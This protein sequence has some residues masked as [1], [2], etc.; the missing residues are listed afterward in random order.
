M[1]LL[2]ETRASGTKVCWFTL[3][4]LFS[5]AGYWCK[6]L[7]APDDTLLKL[8]PLCDWLC[9]IVSVKLDLVISLKAIHGRNEVICG[10]SMSRR[11]INI[12]QAT[13]TSSNKRG[14]LKC[15]D[16][17]LIKIF[18]KGFKDQTSWWYNDSEQVLSVL[19]C[20][21]D[22]SRRTGTS[23]SRGDTLPLSTSSEH[24]PKFYT[25]P[26]TSPGNSILNRTK[27]LTHRVNSTQC[28][29]EST[30]NEGRK[31]IDY[32]GSSTGQSN[33][34][35]PIGCQKSYNSVHDPNTRVDNSTSLCEF[36]G[37]TETLQLEGSKSEQFVSGSNSVS[38]DTK[39]SPP[40][41]RFN[42][43]VTS[44]CPSSSGI[45]SLATG[46]SVTSNSLQNAVGCND[47]QHRIIAPPTPHTCDHELRTGHGDEGTLKG[48]SH[49]LQHPVQEAGPPHSSDIV[50]AIPTVPKRIGLVFGSDWYVV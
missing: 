24:S 29:D 12:D 23:L 31:Q 15:S 40:Y 10:P 35:G 46:S 9:S 16:N 13:A 32:I 20:N 45:G 30:A 27:S 6:R 44:V 38:S 37:Q 34:C 50:V 49:E 14:L 1:S 33:V 39:A 8:T 36:Q 28:D 7:E 3:L 42:C 17:S 25:P 26:P 19:W 21:Q 11:H 5:Y 22:I 18:P 48:T 4:F 2:Q 47:R 43:P 41:V